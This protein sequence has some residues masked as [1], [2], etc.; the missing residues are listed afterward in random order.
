[1]ILKFNN[2]RG[3]VLCSQCLIII[4][5]NFSS[6]EW[7]ALSELELG[8]EGDWFCKECSPVDYIEQGKRFVEK[9]NEIKLREKNNSTGVL[10]SIPLCFDD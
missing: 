4:D 3:A 1:M 2:A 8:G 5:E 6:Y 7:K 9:V 10:G